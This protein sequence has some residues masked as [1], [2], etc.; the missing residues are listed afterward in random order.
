M[1]DLTSQPIKKRLD[2]LDEK[3][4][5]N[6]LNFIN[7]WVGSGYADDFH[8]QVGDYLIN[9]DEYITT[10]DGK[11]YEFCEFFDKWDFTGRVWVET[12]FVLDKEEV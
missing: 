4:K 1:N 8:E 11:T 3:S 5:N 12:K 2:L 7:D 10:T 6:V 9:G